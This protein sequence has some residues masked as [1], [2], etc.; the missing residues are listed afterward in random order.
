MELLF[1]LEDM[2]TARVICHARNPGPLEEGSL[3]RAI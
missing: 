1:V 3:E 2:N